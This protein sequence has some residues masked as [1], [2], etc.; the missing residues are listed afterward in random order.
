MSIVSG[1]YGVYQRKSP[2][3]FGCLECLLEEGYS[4]MRF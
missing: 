4:I 1:F 3:A 2:A